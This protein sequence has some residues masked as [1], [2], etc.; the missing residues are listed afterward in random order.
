MDEKCSPK[1]IKLFITIV[2]RGKGEKIVDMFKKNSIMYNL[3]MLGTGTAKSEILDYLGI[4]ET[5]KDLVLSVVKE[6]DIEKVMNQLK[7]KMQ[8]KKPGNGIAFTIPIN[9]IDSI[10]SL[11]YICSLIG[12]KKEWL[13]GNWKKLWFDNYNS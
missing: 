12:G 5:D 10:H 6:E 3:I 9:S 4:G 11:E 8:L 1:K 13:Y 2:D 7:D